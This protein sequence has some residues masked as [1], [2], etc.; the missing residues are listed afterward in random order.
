MSIALVVTAGFGNGTFNGTIADVVL[1]GYSIG[2]VVVTPDSS[3]SVFGQIDENGQ[4]V[5]GAISENGQGVL[6]RIFDR[7][8]VSGN[9]NES[10][11]SVQG[12]IDETGQSVEG[13]I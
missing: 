5:L 2:E 3:F 12:D 7:F 11:Q 13:K 10:G 6:G 8:S 1:R 4:S 9:I